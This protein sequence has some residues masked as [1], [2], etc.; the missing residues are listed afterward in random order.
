[1]FQ[2]HPTLSSFSRLNM[3]V[4]YATE[5]TAKPSPPKVHLE[6][7]STWGHN[8]LLKKQRKLVHKN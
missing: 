3:T 4:R 2:L 5:V 6:G 1:M 8:V 7:I